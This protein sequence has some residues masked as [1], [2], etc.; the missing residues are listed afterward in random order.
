MK[1][2]SI[3]HS[4]L[5]RGQRIQVEEAFRDLNSERFGLWLSVSRSKHKDPV[6]LQLPIACIASFGCA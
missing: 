4:A 3:P 5:T 2:F 1:T 6:N